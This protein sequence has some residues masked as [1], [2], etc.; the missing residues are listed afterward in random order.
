[1]YFFVVLERW[2]TCYVTFPRKDPHLAQHEALLWFSSKNYCSTFINDKA[3]A[4][5]W[6]LLDDLDYA[7]IFCNWSRK[8]EYHY[9]VQTNNNV[10]EC[11]I[12]LVYIVHTSWCFART[13]SLHSCCSLSPVP[14]SW[15]WVQREIN[16]TKIWCSRQD[17]NTNSPTPFEVYLHRYWS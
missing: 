12:V 15:I 5:G 3:N 10:W 9:I 1:M 14:L 7:K 13:P 16:I 2:G 6:T 4:K 8:E 11:L 17:E